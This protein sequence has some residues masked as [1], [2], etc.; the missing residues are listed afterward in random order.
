MTK[1]EFLSIK[2]KY[3]KAKRY[4]L[5]VA[6]IWALLCAFSAMFI[7]YGDPDGERSGLVNVIGVLAFMGIGIAV[8]YTDL[9]VIKKLNL[10]CPSCHKLLHE[11]DQ[12]LVITTNKC[13]HC[14]ELVINE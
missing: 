1:E 5:V 8:G 10:I 7:I 2:N 6:A 4:P 3:I 12:S 14:G 9:Y 13:P 11:G